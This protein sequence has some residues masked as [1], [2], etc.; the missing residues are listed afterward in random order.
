MSIGWPGDPGGD[1]GT[2]EFRRTLRDHL[3]EQRVVVL[4]G[5]LDHDVAGR[6]A[7]ELMTLDA[8]GDEPIRL[9]LSCADGE[10]DAALS[11]MDVIELVGVPVEALCVGTV[12]G[13]AIGVLAVAGRRQAT[14]TTSLLLRDPGDSFTGSAHDQQRWA[15]HRAD[16]WRI[17]CD[18][19]SGFTHR[20]V[21]EVEA[22][23][24]R[25]RF[26]STTEALDYGLLDEIVQQPS[27]ERRGRL[28]FRPFR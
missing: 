5:R 16:R 9:Q 13:A 25:G 11:L 1:D 4:T 17:F 27:A 19:V 18:R 22:D 20:S 7:I 8:D 24:D 21:D 28:G 6:A 10:L 3:F 2:A 15:Q 14:A 23:F 12:G 26:L